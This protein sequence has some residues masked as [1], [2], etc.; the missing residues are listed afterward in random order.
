MLF[1]EKIWHIFKNFKVYTH[2][3]IAFLLKFSRY[4]ILIIFIYKFLTYLLIRM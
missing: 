2:N 3:I 1:L 4:Y